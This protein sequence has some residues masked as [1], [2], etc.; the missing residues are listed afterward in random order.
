[1]EWLK[2]KFK[3]KRTRFDFDTYMRVL[4]RCNSNYS[5]ALQ[6]YGNAKTYEESMIACNKMVQW[7]NINHKVSKRLYSDHLGY[8]R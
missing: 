6:E 2:R 3:R 7:S 5:K 4:D 8:S 1:M